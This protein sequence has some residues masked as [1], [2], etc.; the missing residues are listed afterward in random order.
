MFFNAVPTFAGVAIAS[1]A[2]AVAAV[3]GVVAL[4]LA[5]I[6]VRAMLDTALDRPN[7]VM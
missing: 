3:G 7:T 4:T 5:S 2:S 6:D 1:A